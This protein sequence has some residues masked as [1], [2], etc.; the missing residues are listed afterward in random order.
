MMKKNKENKGSPT[1]TSDLY[2]CFIQSAY[3]SEKCIEHTIFIVRQKLSE[4]LIKD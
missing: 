1:I 3:L 2:V 4:R